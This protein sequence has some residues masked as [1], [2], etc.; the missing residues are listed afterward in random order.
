M[1]NGGMVASPTGTMVDSEIEPGT[2]NPTEGT[3]PKKHKTRAERRGYSAEPKT[4][5]KI[6]RARKGK[7]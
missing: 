5:A 6:N 7:K 2:P 1:S 4:A 3:H